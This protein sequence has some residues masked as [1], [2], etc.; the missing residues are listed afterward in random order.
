MVNDLRIVAIEETSSLAVRA[1]RIPTW[2]C[3]QVRDAAQR[4]FCIEVHQTFSVV[5]S[6][7]DDLELNLLGEGF[8]PVEDEEKLEA[9]KT[10]MARVVAALTERPVDD[11]LA[12]L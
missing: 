12:N 5:C 8:A 4:A 11:T 10:E 2:V 3:Q 1:I 6:H 9:I 7:D